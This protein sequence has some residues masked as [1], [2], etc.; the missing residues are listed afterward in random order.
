MSFKNYIAM[1]NQ[2]TIEMKDDKKARAVKRNLLGWGGTLLAIGIILFFVGF[3]GFIIAGFKNLQNFQMPITWFILCVVAIPFVAI[4]CIMLRYGLMIVISK[5]AVNYADV[6]DKC[7]QC[8]VCIEGTENFCKKCGFN[9]KK[10]VTCPKCG[11]QCGINDV[12]CKSC[13]EKLKK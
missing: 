6:S 5:I 12:F 3:I 4:G 8:G 7:P 10:N 1:L 13:G 9:I 2:K 11:K